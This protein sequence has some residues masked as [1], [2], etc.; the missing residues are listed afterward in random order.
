MAKTIIAKIIRATTEKSV[1]TITVE[2]DDGK[3]KWQKIYTM[4]NDIVKADHFKSVVA[5]DVR[6]DLH[7]ATQLDEIT[8]LVGSAFTFTV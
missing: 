2:L 1:A 4:R 7:I 8:P 6:K 5:A 3:A